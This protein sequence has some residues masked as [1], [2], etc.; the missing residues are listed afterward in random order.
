[1]KD[2]SVYLISK[3]YDNFWI[4]FN[5]LIIF[6]FWYLFYGLKDLNLLS[7]YVII[8][9]NFAS[10]IVLHG[11][12]NA[13]TFFRAYLNKE[14]R[15]RY[16][17]RIK[18]MPFVFLAMT[19]ISK[20]LFIIMF[21][22]EMFWDYHH[23][24]LQTWG[25]G[26]VYEAKGG[27]PKVGRNID[28][29]FSY[30]MHMIPFISFLYFS[31]VIKTNLLFFRNSSLK[32]IF[33]LTVP[34]TSLLE[35]IA[36]YLWWSFIAFTIYYI[37]YYIREYAKGYRMPKT[38]MLLFLNTYIVFMLIG[39]N[40][41]TALI[42]FIALDSFHAFQTVG[43]TWWSEK[44][45]FGKL[46]NINKN[47]FYKK[48]FALFVIAL[49]FVGGLEALVDYTSE[50]DLYSLTQQSFGAID[51]EHF[52]YGPIGF[53]LRVRLVNNFMHYWCDSFIWS[54]SKKKEVDLHE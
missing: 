52:I 31:E 48:T 3:T 11:F 27:D 42:V 13:S 4:I 37:Y 22:A 9:F 49:L 8:S 10:N 26:R 35:T 51:I 23:T 25:I 32:P 30:G 24:A 45:Q 21:V 2:K 40:A 18:V 6:A 15:N 44:E 54:V 5:P 16:W 39:I 17:F 43:L 36:P 12:G 14:V 53:L 7:I 19:Y 41:H 47:N 29:I 20:E 46:F 38:K 33:D 50:N 34:I 28:R 1:M